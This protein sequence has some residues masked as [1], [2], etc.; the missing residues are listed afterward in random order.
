LI[1][2]VGLQ[3][4]NSV[5]KKLNNQR[6]NFKKGGW[7]FVTTVNEPWGN[8]SPFCLFYHLIFGWGKDYDVFLKCV[9]SMPIQIFVPMSDKKSQKLTKRVERLHKIERIIR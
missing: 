1:N 2:Y 4:F 3:S 5:G 8:T 9:D 7:Y 6:R